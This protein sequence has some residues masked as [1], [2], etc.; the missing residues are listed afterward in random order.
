VNAAAAVAF[1]VA[2]V[3]A[4]ANWVA[5]VRHDRRLEYVAKPATLTALVVA[6]ATLDP[7]DEA[8]RWWFVAALVF[9]LAGDVLLMLPSDRFVAGLA[10]FLVAHLCYVVGF[11]LD[12]P[13][14]LGLLVAAAVVVAFVMPVAA[15]VVRALRGGDDREL[16]VPVVVYIGVITAMVVSAVASGNGVAAAGAVLFAASDSMIAFD[17]FVAPFSAAPVAIMVTYHV[18]QALLV[19]SLVT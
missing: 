4:V 15:Q 14:A 7:T 16:V 17:R 3:F 1:V 2:G 8:Q 12:P 6:A 10:A 18:G 9:S 5:K 11:W 19:A 13:S